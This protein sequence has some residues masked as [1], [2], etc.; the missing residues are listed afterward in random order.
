VGL[1]YAAV[2]ST[3]VSTNDRDYHYGAA[4]RVAL[5]LRMITGDQTST[6]ISA[7]MV[8]MGH[9]SNRSAGRD[10]I[11]RVDTAFTW[12][13]QG[14]HAVGVNYVWSHR[15]ARFPA[16][17]DRRQTLGRVGLYYTLLGREHFGAVDW[18]PP[19]AN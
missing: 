18:R 4:S 7:R 8:S 2:S 9:I 6:D 1:G 15:S 12:R 3:H 13:V 17:G 16:V 10:E 19:A 5:A 14:R 11:S